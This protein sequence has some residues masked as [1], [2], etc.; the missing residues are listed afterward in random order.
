MASK[1]FVTDTG[2]KYI[3]TN[4]VKTYYF[5]TAITGGSTAATVSSAGAA[6]AGSRAVTTHATGRASIFVS[7]GT[8][9]NFLTNA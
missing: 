8:V 5:T 9:W 1:S 7:N 6:A 2:I 4:G 3:D